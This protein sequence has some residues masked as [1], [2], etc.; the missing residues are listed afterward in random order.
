MF[1][2]VRV[3]GVDEWWPDG[4]EFLEKN[5]FPGKKYWKARGVQPKLSPHTAHVWEQVIPSLTSVFSRSFHVLLAT[6]SYTKGVSW[7]SLL[8]LTSAFP[9]LLPEY[10]CIS[11]RRENTT[12]TSH[13]LDG[14]LKAIPGYFLL[15]CY[16]S[17]FMK[18]KKKS[19]SDWYP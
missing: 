16:L 4:Q 8:E 7:R 3:E 6:A 11:E 5:S 9:L 12:R 1:L 13:M 14:S 18:K 10:L 15:I 19:V 2:T 17:L